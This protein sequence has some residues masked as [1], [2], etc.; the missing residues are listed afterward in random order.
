MEQN[1]SNS[2]SSN[3]PKPFLKWAGG[4]TQLLDDIESYLPN[5]FRSEITKY[6]EP[7]VGGGA[8]FFRLISKYDFDYIYLGDINGDLILTYTVIRDN[9]DELKI[10]LRDLD[11]EY[12]EK[13]E[14]ERK[15]M[16]YTTR[17]DFNIIHC[18]GSKIPTKNH[19]EIASKMIFLN[20]TCFN[21]LYRVN[22]KGSFNVPFANPK[23]PL[24][25]DERNLS[26]V[27]LALENVNI[28]HADYHKSIKNMDEHSFVYLD[29][30]YKPINGKKYFEGYSKS[31]FNDDNQRELK[32][33]CIK[34]NDEKHAKFILNNSD[35]TNFNKNDC[36]FEDLYKDFNKVPVYA[37]RSINSDAKKR[38][39]IRELLIYNF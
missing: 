3:P 2:K 32:D 6:F 35:P 24:I 12:Y 27:S 10:L 25:Y 31:S 9:L 16:F 21:G 13:S 1:K 11:K 30:P 8:V 34:I 28:E 7:F 4:K 29:P 5:N 37:K 23:K 17:E 26:K 39:N 19:V 36:F 18:K 38:G 20:K 15:E 33:F 22:Q 14:L